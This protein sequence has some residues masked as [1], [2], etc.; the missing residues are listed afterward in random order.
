MKK[1]DQKKID[2]IKTAEKRF[3]RHGFYKTSLD[4]IA[5]DLRIGKT[6][7]YHYFESKDLLYIETIKQEIN[8]LLNSIK[9]ILNNEEIICKNR[10]IEYFK[11]IASL[12]ENYN[13]VYKIFLNLLNET[14]KEWEIKIIKDLLTGELELLKLFFQKNL[15]DSNKSEIE[16]LASKILLFTKG[17]MLTGD[18]RKN[19]YLPQNDEQYEFEKEIEQL[20]F[21]E[22]QS[23]SPS[24]GSS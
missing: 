19:N 18:I 14:I 10:L 9:L 22:T 24:S 5:R 1:F 3:S 17:L 13:L 15:A 2:I 21:K 8:E 12:K 4:E 7:I 16:K 11:L 23:S 6:T 20:N